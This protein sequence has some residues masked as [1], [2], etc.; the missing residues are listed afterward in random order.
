[1]FTTRESPTSI[2][3]FFNSV[4]SGL[5]EDKEKGDFITEFLEWKH[6]TDPDKRQTSLLLSFG[7]PDIDYGIPQIR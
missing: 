2:S 3:F 6:E 4:I 5:L 7:A 1:M